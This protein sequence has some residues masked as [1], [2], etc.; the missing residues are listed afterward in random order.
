[1]KYGEIMPGSGFS[2]CVER[3]MCSGDPNRLHKLET[4]N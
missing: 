4:R 1:L 2:H 3:T